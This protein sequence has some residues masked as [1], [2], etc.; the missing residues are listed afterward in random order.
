M[1]SAATQDH[2]ETPSTIAAS[3]PRS[4]ASSGVHFSKAQQQS[5]Q[6]SVRAASGK[7]IM[8]AGEIFGDLMGMQ[9]AL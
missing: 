9:C 5:S 4:K 7:R 3:A 6:S 1:N 8:H 2:S